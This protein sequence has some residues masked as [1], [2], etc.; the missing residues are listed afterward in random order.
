MILIHSAVLY[1]FEPFVQSM[2]MFT[3]RE[4]TF[5]RIDFCGNYFCE[6]M[7]IKIKILQHLILANARAKKTFAAFIITNDRLLRIL[8]IQFLEYCFDKVLRVV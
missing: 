6:L 4:L 3:L 7:A 8:R 2:Y 5:A 1:R